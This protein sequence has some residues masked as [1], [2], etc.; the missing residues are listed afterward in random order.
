[1]NEKSKNSIELI[2]NNTIRLKAIGPQKPIFIRSENQ[3][4]KK[5]V[6]DLH[7]KG[8]RAYLIIDTSEITVK[9]VSMKARNEAKNTRKIGFDAIAFFGNSRL[10]DVVNYIVSLRPGETPVKSFSSESAAQQWLNHNPTNA[11][12]LKEQKNSLTPVV[13]V[14]ALIIQLS[15][16]SVWEYT[17]VNLDTNS[18]ESFESRTSQIKMTLNDRIQAY[19]DALYGFRALYASSD[20]VNQGEFENYFNSTDIKNKYPGFETISFIAR[21]SEDRLQSFETQQKQDTS[22]NPNGRQT[23]EIKNLSDLSTHYIVTFLADSPGISTSFGSDLSGNNDRLENF[24]RALKLGDPTASETLTFETFEPGN[25]EGFIITM[26]V[27]VKNASTEDLAAGKGVINAVFGYRDYFNDLFA[28]TPGLFDDVNIEVIEPE[29]Q[30]TIFTNYNLEGN[31]KDFR[32]NSTTIDVAGRTWVLNTQAHNLFDTTLI[33]R[34]TPIATLLLGE[35]LFALLAFVLYL[36]QRSRESGYKLAEVIT[37]DLKLE[38]N[39]AVATQYKD[40]AVL[41]SIGEG[42]C[43]FDRNGR[44]EKLNTKALKLL[45]AK[46]E[47]LVGKKYYD[48]YEVLDRKQKNIPTKKRPAYVALSQGKAQNKN[49]YF[50]RMDGS[51]FPATVSISPVRD[52]KGKI[53]GAV[54]IFRDRT[55]ETQLEYAKTDFISLASHQLS[56][57]ATAVKGYLS[58]IRDGYMK[59]KKETN[60]A[61]EQAYNSNERQIKIVQNL[62]NVARIENSRL[63]AEKTNFDLV[64]LANECIHEQSVSTKDRS[65]KVK[66]KSPKKLPITSDQSLLGFCLTNLISNASKY[67]PHGTTITVEVADHKDHNCIKVSD[68]G[69]GIAV[70]DQKKLF[71]R[72]S[73]IPNKFS[74]TVTGTGLG[75]YIIK[76]TLDL[77]KGDIKLESELGKGSTFTI[78]LPKGGK[79]A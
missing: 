26:P 57:P 2:S 24:E 66:L 77:L 36:Q 22:L 29:N 13:I 18:R 64:K 37:K 59:N 3:K 12:Y 58:L 1:M 71:K 10:L 67:S 19:N 61:L 30:D 31:E 48:A 8:E 27:Y 46:Q 25:Q 42:L 38:R 74:T 52:S 62:L 44:I 15:I 40:E 49:L 16:F 69:V 73:R 53:T 45:K 9:D 75:L 28:S 72:F 79:N 65:Q 70:E 32:K 47:D 39:K 51:L 7:S 20:E 17:R 68:H 35:A 55:A 54:E 6:A 43:I 23:F 76:Q 33:E 11:S 56:T 14:L 4:M 5:M 21:V 34:L 50:E 41:E 78:Q 63:K 60:E